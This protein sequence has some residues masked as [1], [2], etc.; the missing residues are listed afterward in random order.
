L[1]E[2]SKHFSKREASVN[3]GREGLVF[4]DDKNERQVLSFYKC[5]PDFFRLAYHLV[6]LKIKNLK[7]CGKITLR[8]FVF[9]K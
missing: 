8:T 9:E 7:G 2:A 4:A 1:P 5:N 6:T 3:H